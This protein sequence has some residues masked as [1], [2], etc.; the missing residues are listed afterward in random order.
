MITKYEYDC[1]RLS[2]FDK[3]RLK[4]SAMLKRFISVF[5]TVYEQTGKKNNT[6]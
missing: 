1:S 6:I 2:T 4:L 3:Y 5:F